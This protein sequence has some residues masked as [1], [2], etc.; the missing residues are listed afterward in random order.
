MGESFSYII[1]KMTNFIM[2]MA[3][4]AVFCALTATIGVNGLSIIVS[5]GKFMGEF[6]LALFVLCSRLSVSH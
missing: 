3:P 1:L 4:I 2:L 5:Y 6:Y